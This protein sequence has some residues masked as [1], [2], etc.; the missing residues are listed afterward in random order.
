MSGTPF[1]KTCSDRGSPNGRGALAGEDIPSGSRWNQLGHHLFHDL[2]SNPVGSLMVID[3]LG[4][5]FSLGLLGK[6][7]ILKP[8]HAITSWIDRWFASPVPTQIAVSSP[9]DSMNVRGDDVPADGNSARDGPRVLRS[10]EGH[11]Y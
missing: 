5:F 4:L 8:Y 1:S 2:K 10:R 11:L 7:L 6:T 9:S 3:V